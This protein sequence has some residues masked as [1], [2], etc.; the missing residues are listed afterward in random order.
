MNTKE[1][2][3]KCLAKTVYLTGLSN[4]AVVMLIAE[5]NGVT[6]Q[7]VYAWLNNETF[8]DRARVLYALQEIER[9]YTEQSA[10]V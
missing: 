4:G 10:T 8:S 9:D 3:K 5:M 1:P 7:T 6:R 2:L